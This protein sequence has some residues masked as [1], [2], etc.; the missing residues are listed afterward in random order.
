MP[1][2]ED[3]D[4]RIEYALLLFELVKLTVLTDLTLV[5]GNTVILI[6]TGVELT[7]RWIYRVPPSLGFPGGHQ[8]GRIKIRLGILW[9][10]LLHKPPRLLRQLSQ[11]GLVLLLRVQPL[12]ATVDLRSGGVG[13][14]EQ[15]KEHEQRAHSGGNFNPR[16]GTA[17]LCESLRPPHL[18][19][20]QRFPA[21]GRWEKRAST[22]QTCTHRRCRKA[23]RGHRAMRGQVARR[24]QA[25]CSRQRRR[26]RGHPSG[27]APFQAHRLCRFGRQRGPF[28]TRRTRALGSC[29]YARPPEGAPAASGMR[30]L[31][32]VECALKLA[33]RAPGLAARRPTSGNQ[34][35]PLPLVGPRSAHWILP[36]G[37]PQ[38]ALV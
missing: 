17:R 1:R 22:L 21:R 32:T 30:Y 8:R 13:G 27:T 35:Q 31:P 2:I 18:L 38:R 9:Y 19:E 7:R 34:L 5:T 36:S 28:G 12:R 20:A 10:T 23:Y 15:H 6:H 29:R 26:D 37:T 24:S 11:T 4:F 14:V 25:P 3:G 33:E 16:P